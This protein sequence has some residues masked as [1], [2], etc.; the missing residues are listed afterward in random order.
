MQER[1]LAAW[2]DAGVIDAEAVARIRDYEASHTRP[3]ALWAVIGLGALAIG[4]GIVLVVAANWDAIPQMLRLSLHFGL[5]AAGV[6]V[7]AWRGKSLAARQPMALDAALFVLGM[8]G[9][10]FMGHLGQVYQT[11][12]PLWQPIALWLV[13]FGPLLLLRGQSWLCAGLIVVP[14]VYA[15]WNYAE[16]FGSS[17]WWR[18]NQPSS[19]AIGLAT[20]APVLLAG[21]AAWLRGLSQRTTFWRRLEQMAVGYA[22]AGAS[23]L[24]LIS[25]WDDFSRNG[26]NG[27]AFNTITIY[28]VIGLIAAGLIA[29]G[30]RNRSGQGSAMIVAAA[31][32]ACLMA[33][34]ISGSQIGGATLFMG[35]WSWIA[36][37]SLH[38]GWRGVFQIAVGA[39]ALRLIG[40]SF[41]LQNDLLS[42]GAGLIV[43]GL[44]M[45][46][47]AWGAVRIARK[48][49]PPR[50]HAA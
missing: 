44:L 48:Y 25:G 29:T 3:L 15:G 32:L 16:G 19:L 10:A 12:S 4:L 20:A 42:N 41:E 2:L 14:M 1:K 31:A 27:I 49:A 39:V 46:G 36:A 45:L 47:I 5:L 40:L 17:W 37:A 35:L 30:R 18:H 13:L 11:S 8:L 38:G 26:E 28:A 43:T 50:E 34:P 23:V 7:I 6:A 21:P 22:A 33:W 24:A 9:M